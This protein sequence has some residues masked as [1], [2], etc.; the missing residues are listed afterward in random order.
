MQITP[1]LS[2]TLEQRSLFSLD[3]ILVTGD[4]FEEISRL[5]AQLANEFE[6]KDLGE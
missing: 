3:D 4:D 5:K 2:N 1:S 6:I